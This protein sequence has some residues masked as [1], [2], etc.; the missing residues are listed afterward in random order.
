MVNSTY[1]GLCMV[2]NQP[3]DPILICIATMYILFGIVYTLFGYRCFKAVMFLTGFIFASNIVYL[4]CI[5]ENVL[6]GY[7]NAGIAICLGLLFGLI[8]MLVQYVGLFMTGFHTGL[9]LAIAGIVAVDQF[10]APPTLLTS[11]ATL[12]GV[13]LLFAILNLHWQKGLTLF[14]TCVY[15]GGLITFSVD[16][17]SEL[18]RTVKWLWRR[19]GPPCYPVLALWPAVL[20]LGLA[21][22]I[23]LTSPTHHSGKHVGR[24]RT[25]EQRAELRQNK[26]RYLYQVR[27]AHGDVISQNYVQ[28]IQ[29]KVVGP[30]ET[31]TLES[32]ATHLTMLPDGQTD[33]S[34]G[35]YYR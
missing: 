20:C 29:N 25:R 10:Y 28:A 19:Q 14:G 3:T 18:M 2:D 24:P 12:M 16:Y 1:L 7:V 27:T 34:R 33:F 5:E 8:T 9:A 6:P 35:N 23:S 30:G 15:G 4:I 31:S 17:L 22:Q 26:Y 21:V 13:G 11:I 32:D